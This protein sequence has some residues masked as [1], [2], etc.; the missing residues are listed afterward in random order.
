[1]DSGA[2]G[3]VVASS[4]NKWLPLNMRFVVHVHRLGSGD[5]LREQLARNAVP[6]EGDKA[7][8]YSKTQMITRELLL[9]C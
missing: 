4:T 7:T 5:S 3:W 1:M 2:G 6:A 8:M 9:Q